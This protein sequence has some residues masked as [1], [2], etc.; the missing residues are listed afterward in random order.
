MVQVNAVTASDS[1][2]QDCDDEQ[3]D[4]EQ[5]DREQFDRGRDRENYDYDVTIVGGGIVGSLAA[6]A[7]SGLGLKIAL[8]EAS[9]QSLA[10]ARGQ[11]YSL[12]LLSSQIFDQL[13]LWQRIR[14]QIETYTQVYLSDGHYPR[15]V[16]FSPQDIQAETLG[17]VA[18][19]RILLTELQTQL[20]QC[21]DVTW[22]CPAKVLQIDFQPH[23][24]ILTIEQSGIV[25]T[26]RS[27]L[28]IGADGARSPI[29]QQVGIKTYG[30]QYWQSCVVAFIKPEKSH[31]N[32][33]YE[34]FQTDGPFAILPLPDNLCRIVWTVPHS[35]AE[36]ILK[37]DRSSFLQELTQRYGS[38]MGKLDLV[39]E[40][41]VFP[42]RL[43]HSTQ[44]V[45]PRLALIGDAAHCCHP[46]GGQGMNLGIRDAAALVEVI[47]TAH[48]RGE[49]FANLKVLKRY[50]RW[51]MVENVIVLAFT[52]LLDRLFSNR[53]LPIVGLRRMGLWIL[54]NIQ[55][56]KTQV[57]RL[58]LGLTGR[59]PQL[60][61]VN[62]PRIAVHGLQR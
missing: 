48:S 59:S 13:G 1:L 3:F 52:D 35:E 38:Q 22:L 31:S 14:P 39:G 20:R 4:R 33:A 51:R 50:E 9:Q 40:P 26:V 47:R 30:W 46:V 61:A 45:Q 56:I 25:T 8:I 32:I 62:P 53:I 57:L 6:C 19:H 7:L 36:R 24:A 28:A 42:V 58:M 10:V 54:G 12:N 5:F 41:Y 21:A 49:D 44:Y 55:P 11:A 29:R 2:Q 18:E 27:R 34:R 60:V 23:A 43:L 37:L 16:H 15:V 17:Y